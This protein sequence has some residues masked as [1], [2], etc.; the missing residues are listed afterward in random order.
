[1]D[2]KPK[3]YPHPVLKEDTDDYVSSKFSCKLKQKRGMKKFIFTAEFTLD[4][5]ELLKLI[6]KEKVEYVLH[7]EC[8]QSSFRKVFSS[9]NATFSFE[10]E[11][12]S[13]L[14]KVSIC[15]FLLA[16]NNISQYYNADFDDDYQ[17]SSFSL[18]KGS[19]LAIGSQEV[20]IVEKDKNDLASVPSIFKIFHKEGKVGD[21]ATVEL[22][23]NN[24]RI[25]LCK[26][27]YENY[28][29]QSRGNTHT[30]NAF[31]IFP[32]LIYALEYLKKD[33]QESEEMKWVQALTFALKKGGYT[34]NQDLLDMIPSFQLAQILMMS[35]ITSAFTEIE[36]H[37]NSLEDD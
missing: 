25:G 1:M 33:F 7:V 23:N 29:H 10:L 15:S 24:I 22:D 20:F 18:V 16:K 17:D 27:D 8:S 21:P 2:I 4:N 3:L 6:E 14:G 12:K 13:L 11:D 19:I 37:F 5:G 32:A 34:L 28:H 30:I 26:A 35:P 9:K 36:E 31:L